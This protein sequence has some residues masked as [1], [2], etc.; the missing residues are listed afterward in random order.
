VQLSVMLEPQEGIGYAEQLAVARHAEA[1]GFAG[2]YRSDHYLSV[3][4]REGLGSTDAWAA[5]AG[6]ARDTERI[7][8]GTLVSPV[9][10]R[11]AGNLAKV[12]ATVDE[13]AGPAPDGASRVVLG[14]GT[15]WLEAEH[16]QHGFPFEDLG[17]RFDRLSEHLTAVTRLWDP[18]LAEVDVHGRFVDITAGRFHP[19]PDP[20]PR[21][22]VGGKGLR[23]TPALAAGFADELNGVFLS[24][25]AC[26]AQRRALDHACREVGR[27]PSTVAYSLMTG[28]IVGADEADVRERAARLRERSSTG[29]GD[30]DEWLAGLRGEWVLGTPEQAAA[31]LDE[32]ARAGV[33]Q[34]MLQHLLHDDLGMLDVVAEHLLSRS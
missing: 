11:P 12:V 29:G 25:E 18:D 8:I 16:T 1:L 7:R 33:E 3:A 20:R 28:C 14:M 30:L 2:F 21:I 10:F 5:L 13:L 15:G 22:V 19:K 17:T 4:G 34:V 31:R 32:L 6:I 27:D 26:A 24:P 9:T 23:R